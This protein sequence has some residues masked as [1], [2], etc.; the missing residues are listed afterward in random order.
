MLTSKTPYNAL[1]DEEETIIIPKGSNQGQSMKIS[2]KGN[3]SDTEGPVGDMIIKVN[4][5]SDSYFKRE[6]Y[7]IYTD[8]LLTISQAVLGST[9][10]IKTLYG[11]IDVKIDRGTQHG[12][13]RKLSNYGVS[14][15]APNHNQKGNHYIVF[16]LAVP[17][18]LRPDQIKVFEELKKKNEDPIEITHAFHNETT[19]SKTKHNKATARPPEDNS[20]EEESSGG[21]FDKMKSAFKSKK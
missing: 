10:S 16:K 9:A 8:C 19:S 14:K 13:K 21:F 15:L 18:S 2:G 17:F 11:D 7:D 3:V 4:V 20:Q 1:I 5:R 12:E 6:G